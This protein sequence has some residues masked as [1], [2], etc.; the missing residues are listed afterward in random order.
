MKHGKEV[1]REDKGDGARPGG[2][3]GRP[4]RGAR[5][6]KSGARGA[7]ERPRSGQEQPRSSKGPQEG[8]RTA[9]GGPQDGL[10]RPPGGST[11]AS[12][13]RQDEPSTKETGQE[14]TRGAK[15]A[16][17]LHVS[18]NGQKVFRNH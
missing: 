7:Q 8:P 5:G 11:K 2:A 18:T 6:P 3:P 9:P 1:T 13:R 15:H 12:K 4:K 10:K 14:E 16:T 17:T